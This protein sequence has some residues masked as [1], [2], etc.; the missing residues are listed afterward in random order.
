MLALGA[1]SFDTFAPKSSR[2]V[3][4]IVNT[5]SGFGILRP[6]LYIYTHNIL[7][8][9]DPKEK[10]RFL[11]PL[12]RISSF[13]LCRRKKKGQRPS[14][15]VAAMDE[16]D[17]MSVVLGCN[18]GNLAAAPSSSIPLAFLAPPA[19]FFSVAE[20]ESLAMAAFEFPDFSMMS[21]GLEDLFV[22]S[23][24]PQP[25]LLI[26]QQHQQKESFFV[27]SSVSSSIVGGGFVHPMPDMVV[28]QPPP[29]QKLQA[30]AAV[31]VKRR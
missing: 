3:L 23:Q 24:P 28:P 26:Q 30:A 22:P 11:S 31:R 27:P 19:P 16:G 6:H 1:F 15:S 13:P 20:M 18:G 4:W 14:L 17:L 7:P 9:S 8:F 12:S 2:A 5:A 25:P 29:P 21:G 10:P